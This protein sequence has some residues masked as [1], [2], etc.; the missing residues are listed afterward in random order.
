VEGL[1]RAGDIN[2]GGP[3]VGGGVALSEV[4]GFDGGVVGADLLL[5][6]G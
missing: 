2:G 6:W 3:V 4:V 5:C 1:F